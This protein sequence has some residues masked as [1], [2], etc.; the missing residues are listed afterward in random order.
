MNERLG[1]EKLTGLLGQKP[2]FL[3]HQPL[4]SGMMV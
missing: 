1:E 3:L 2:K 4:S